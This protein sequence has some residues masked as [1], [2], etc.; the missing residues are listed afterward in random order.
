MRRFKELKK[1]IRVNGYGYLFSYTGEIPNLTHYQEIIPLDEIEDIPPEIA[2]YSYGF[3]YLYKD[4]GDLVK[5]IYSLV[6]GLDLRW[7][8]DL[9][10]FL[11]VNPDMYQAIITSS[12]LTG[13]LEEIKPRLE[14]ISNAFKSWIRETPDLSFLGQRGDRDYLNLL[15]RDYDIK[16]CIQVSKKCIKLIS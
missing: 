15:C 12:I 14:D 4:M 5:E 1:S 10:K 7:Q 16:N 13:I 2:E 8:G 3:I 6:E 11:E 9:F